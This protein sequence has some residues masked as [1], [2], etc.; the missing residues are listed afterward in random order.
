MAE[1]GTRTKPRASSPF[2]QA[3]MR[4]DRDGIEKG[5]ADR[6]AIGARLGFQ[7]GEMAVD[8]QRG[9]DAV[10]RFGRLGEGRA[11]AAR[12]IGRHRLGGRAIVVE[13]KPAAGQI[14]QGRRQRLGCPTG[15]AGP[16]DWSRRHSR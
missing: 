9:L 10:Q 13:I 15:S 14:G 8:F 2:A 1:T 11:G 6:A 4:V 12:D 16:E 7:L 3:A 5:R